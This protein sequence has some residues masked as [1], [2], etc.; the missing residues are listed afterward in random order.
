MNARKLRIYEMELA[1]HAAFDR[2]ERLACRLAFHS[3]HAKHID[4]ARAVAVRMDR[5]AA[6]IQMFGFIE[7]D[8]TKEA[9]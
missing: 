6:V 8:L 1:A 5:L 7:I 2:A 4:R 9:L 3:R